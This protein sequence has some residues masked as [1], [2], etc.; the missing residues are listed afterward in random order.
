MYVQAC[1]DGKI[2]VDGRIA[3]VSGDWLSF[4]DGAINN[5]PNAL[6]LLLDADPIHVKLTKLDDEIGDKFEKDIH[7]LLSKVVSKLKDFSDG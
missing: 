1:R 3:D 2:D 4:T 6:N 7:S 5:H